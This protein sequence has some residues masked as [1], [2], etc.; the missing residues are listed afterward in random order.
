[1][2][3]DAFTVINEDLTFADIKKDLCDSGIPEATLL[4]SHY[5]LKP[6]W[7]EPDPTSKIG[8]ICQTLYAVRAEGFPFILALVR[9]AEVNYPVV[10]CKIHI[11]SLGCAMTILFS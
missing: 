3:I 1:V 9:H 11:S 2:D 7:T 4:R 10:I 5:G 8:P 6:Y